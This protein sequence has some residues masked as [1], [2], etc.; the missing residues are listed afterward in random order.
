MQCCVVSTC[1][2]KEI[3]GHAMLVMLVQ[4]PHLVCGFLCF[5]GDF[6]TRN[7]RDIRTS[8]TEGLAQAH[9]KYVN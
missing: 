6:R 2:A 7:T 5:I 4:P 1:F 9:P 8:T 3:L